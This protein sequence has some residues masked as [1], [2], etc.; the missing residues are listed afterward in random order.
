MA[1]VLLIDSDPSS[2][3][4]LKQP[5]EA[6]KLTVESIATGAGGLAAALERPPTLIAL[7]LDLS[8]QDGL[9]ILKTIRGR[10]RTAHIPIFVLASRMQSSRQNMVL[11]AGADD[12][13]SKPFDADIVA[14]RIRNAVQRAEREGLTHPQTGLPSGRLLQERIRQLAD[15]LDWY[16]IDL[17]IENFDAFRE[18]YGFMTGQELI[19]FA[20]GVL[21][22]CVR[23]AG[24]PGDFIGQR[25]DTEYVVITDIPH[26]LA[27][28]AVIRQRVNDGVLS[29]YT[30][31]E[32]EQ[33]Y[34]ALADAA[35]GATHIP[36]M[37]ARIK[38]QQ[39]EEG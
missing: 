15:D 17:A 29:F 35:G 26:G 30:Y 8:D 13:I 24:T 25:S 3:L 27:L 11:Q 18:A 9:D 4:V 31:L 34:M 38:S 36:L 22:D 37:R 39:S 28:E 20:G 2:A 19:T 10:M 14:L 5:L 21:A 1:R 32:R 12:F 6:F 16:K 7:A 23:D 33:G